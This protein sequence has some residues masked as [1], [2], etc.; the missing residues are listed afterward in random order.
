[1]I[2]KI[3]ILLLLLALLTPLAKAQETIDIETDGLT[4]GLD[5]EVAELLPKFDRQETVD[6]WDTLKNMLFGS[7]IKASDAYKEALKLCAIL[8]CVLTLCALAHMSG[9]EHSSNA[10]VVVGAIGI[11][12][13]VMGSMQSMVHLAQKTIEDM[14]S[15]SAC[16]LPVMASATMMSGGIS[17]GSILYSGTVLFSRLLMS[18]IKNLLIPGV[19]FYIAVAAAEA[20]IGNQ[21]L[22]EIREFIGWLI[23]KCLRIMMFIFIAY[24]TIT[25]VVSGSSD[26]TTLKATKAAVSGMIPVVG[27]IVSDASE[28]MIAGAL[29]L[30]NS[31]G[32]FGMLAVIAIC[33]LPFLRVGVQ[34][35]LMKI[36]AAVSGTV[37]LEPHVK[38]VKHFSQAMGYLLGMCGAYA[39]MLLISSVCFL[40]VVI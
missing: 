39:L 22:S 28:S 24:M 25:G 11:T 34:Y 9:G 21:T 33:L 12:V 29:M 6:F 19:W 13:A 20:A 40:K 4:E 27:S 38:L 7:F 26:A 10:V 3:I 8:L 35:L 30:K 37:G 14:S 2:R 23:S 36:T 18:L 1:M 17:S 31:V 32:I 15:Y 16:F 5:D